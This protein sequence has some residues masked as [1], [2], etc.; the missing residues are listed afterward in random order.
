MNN[1]GNSG[2]FGG[3][4]FH[5]SP[6]GAHGEINPEDIFNIFFNGGQFRQ[7][8][9]GRGQGFH[10]FGGNSQNARAPE[11]T[12]A[13]GETKTLTSQLFQFLPMLLLFLLLFSSSASNTQSAP[14]F[15]MQPSSVYKYPQVTRL[16]EHAM[17]G[18]PFYVSDDLYSRSLREEDKIMLEKQVQHQYSTMLHSKC[19]QEKNDNRFYSKKSNDKC[20]ELSK[21]KKRHADWKN[22]DW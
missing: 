14:L 22:Q 20:D 16:Q 5:G 6:F 8:G 9:G 10:P 18:I 4:G 12:H 17:P 11:H 7:R 15:S 1:A 21:F 3:A 2:G 13:E 19:T